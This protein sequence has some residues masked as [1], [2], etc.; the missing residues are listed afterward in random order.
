MFT[1]IKTNKDFLFCIIVLLWLILGIIS[2]MIFHI[3]IWLF[4]NIMIIIVAI[5]CLFKIYN[6]KFAAWLEKEA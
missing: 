4:T 5:L 1:P 2:V 3:T 6:R